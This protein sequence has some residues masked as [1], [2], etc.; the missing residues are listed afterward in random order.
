MNSFSSWVYTWK[1]GSCVSQQG[2]SLPAWTAKLLSGNGVENVAP[3][4]CLVGGETFAFLG[5]LN[6]QGIDFLMG[7]RGGGDGRERAGLSGFSQG[8]EQVPGKCQ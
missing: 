4:V 1:E 7:G 2:V 5:S 6:S 3:G 8:G